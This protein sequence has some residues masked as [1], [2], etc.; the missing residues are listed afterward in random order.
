M[1]FDILYCLTLVGIFYL[2]LAIT[3]LAVNTACRVSP[4]FRRWFNGII[5]VSSVDF[6]VP[7][8]MAADIKHRIL[9]YNFESEEPLLTHHKHS[10][11][12]GFRYFTFDSDCRGD[13]SVVLDMLPNGSEIAY[14]I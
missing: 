1:V 10:K 11:D 6:R 13:I 4:K 2:L 14:G 5:G 3:E 9:S 7:V 8:G 12:D